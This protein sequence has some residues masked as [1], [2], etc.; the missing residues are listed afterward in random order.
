MKAKL[1]VT[2]AYFNIFPI[3]TEKIKN[4]VN[5]LK[6]RNFIF[7]E[8]KLTLMTERRICDAFGGSFNTEVYSF[9]NFL[10]AKK[11]VARSLS[12]EGSA[13]AVKRILQTIPLKRFNRGKSNL[14]PSL[15][16]LISQLKSAKVTPEDLFYAA[17]KTDG[18]LSAK[19]T[20]IAEVFSAYEKYL[21]E[22]EFVDQSS[23]LS[24]L[25][26]ILGKDEEIEGSEVFIVGYSGFTVQIQNII[27]TLLKR[28]KCVTAILVNGKNT[29]AFVGETERVFGKICKETGVCFD[30]EYISADYSAKG[31]L[32]KD[33]LFNPAFRFSGEKQEV[34]LLASVNA[35][36]EI[37]RIAEVIK[38]KVLS[39]DCRY[40][41]A[42]LIVPDSEEYKEA[43]KRSFN[44]LKIPYFL[45]AKRKPENFPIVSLIYAYID[46]FIKGFTV[47][48][49][50]A[51][52][53]NPY[54]CEDADF[55]DRVEN[56]IYKYDINYDKFKKPFT[57]PAKDDKELEE[58][59]KFRQKIVGIFSEF[60]VKK[61]LDA[62]NA[63][64]TTEELSARLAQI[65]E[66]E[67]STVLVQTYKKVK[68]ILD[69][70]G[71]ILDGIKLDYIEFKTV[72]QSG[73]SAM[74][75]SV[76]PQYNDAVFIGNF[77]QA[78]LC[79]AKYLFAAGLTD[80]VPSFKNDVALLSDGDIDCLADIRVLIEP[81]IQ[82][83]NKR[84][85]EEVVTGL[86]AFDKALYLSYPLSDFGG[87][88]TIKS[89][90]FMYLEKFFT[91]SPFPKFDGYLTEEQ[92]LRSFSRDC[93]RFAENKI[94]DFSVQSGYYV[95]SGNKPDAIVSYAN[96]EIKE[97]IE[98]RGEVLLNGINSP[99][100]IESY[101]K[102]PFKAFAERAL[103][104][105]ERERGEINS[106]LVGNF[107]HAIFFEFMKKSDSVDTEEK[108]EKLYDEI[109]DKILSE[110]E[111]VIFDEGENEYS[112]R[113]AVK[114]CKKYCLKL[115]RWKNSSAFKPL[116]GGLEASFGEGC[117]FP[118]ITLLNGKVKIKGKI[119]RIDENKE[120]FRIL[121]Y[122]T[123]DK[124]FVTK[125]FYV[126]K[127]LQLFMYS[128]VIPDKKLLGAYYVRINDEFKNENDKEK[129]IACGKTISGSIDEK[130]SDFIKTG[131]SGTVS[132]A[133]MQDFRKYAEIMAENAV[134]G[135]EK[136]VIIAS[137][138]EGACNY[139]PYSAMCGKPFEERK[140]GSVSDDGISAAVSGY[141]ENMQ[142]D[143]A[144]QG[145]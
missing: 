79:K 98:N 94:K 31:A 8:E 62:L 128:L 52:F 75:I 46:V 2:D 25:P 7:C 10:R 74:E 42:T 142:K 5:G 81:K 32:V 101:Y 45:D 117:K 36:T 21:K 30:K 136:G 124:D 87:K 143:S 105:N 126:G 116:N 3:L 72:F 121:D 28:A 134:S 138:Y 89:E 92:G 144:K 61:M 19:L 93:S 137:P 73:I 108:A 14:A 11:T 76:I 140:T 20:D 110:K 27:A 83:V 141:Y 133:V 6:E 53:K 55:T 35:F 29:F 85:K 131:T 66:P 132:E 12:K 37:E 111:Y 24:D 44:R 51:F 4:S 95:A 107:M 22:K 18:I 65:G 130:E 15:F 113:L 47:K 80:A 67:D 50:A 120:G 100:A 48:T 17:E 23:A 70:I 59:E 103:N 96:K 43:V 49:A 13:M 115:Y 56:Y 129:A 145:E 139:C 41:D 9:G 97:R 26:E 63:E 88:N 82:V 90:V 64:N 99:T 33:G 112:L 123:G 119:D 68:E 122:K 104:I 84:L 78:A 102:C 91:F 114:E 71:D 57:L 118:P 39:G 1:I 69:N 109:K 38:R 106:L 40:R 86:S 16:E 58:F 60:N 127:S 77:K 125:D 34:F 54:V 135:I